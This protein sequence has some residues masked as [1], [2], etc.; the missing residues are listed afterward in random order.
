MAAD[1]DLFPSGPWTGFY[2]YTG[3]EDRHRM[4]LH[5]TFSDGHIAGDGN[6]NVGRFLINGRYNI[7]DRECEWTKTY[8]GS[9]EVIYRGFREGKGIWGTWQIP[10][11]SRGGFHI[12]PRGAGGS[13]EESRKAEADL[14]VA[15]IGHE[16]NTPAPRS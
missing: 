6:D 12:W 15:A 8:P 5:L 2:N 13:V 10:P 14:P 3:P 7:A 16:S 9:H 4:D 11:L 1:D